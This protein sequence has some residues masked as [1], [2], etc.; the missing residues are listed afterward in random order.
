MDYLIRFRKDG[1][2]INL[3]D[4]YKT[5]DLERLT[6]KGMRFYQNHIL[7]GD[8]LASKNRKG[9][10]LIKGKDFL[11]FLTIYNLTQKSKLAKLA[12]EYEHD[13]DKLFVEC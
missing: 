8:L 9:A 7:R 12:A 2:R 4:S 13:Y 3:K 5:A 6:N 1:E 11:A 10:Y